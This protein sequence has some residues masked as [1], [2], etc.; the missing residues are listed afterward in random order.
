[1]SERTEIS[2][3]FVNLHKYSNIADWV[4]G[5]C[6]TVKSNNQMLDTIYSRLI[7]ET[8][9]EVREVGENYFEIE[10]SS[11]YTKNGYSVIFNFEKPE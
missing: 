9:G 6:D 8:Y 11:H 2:Q 7:D 3:D 10:I 5:Y 1:M 4:Q